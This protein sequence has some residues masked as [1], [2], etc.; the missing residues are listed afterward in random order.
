MLRGG[1]GGGGGFIVYANVNDASVPYI[2]PI[3]FQPGMT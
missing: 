2:V 3:L 1:G